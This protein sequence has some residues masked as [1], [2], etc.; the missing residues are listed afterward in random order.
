MCAREAAIV[1]WRAASAAT[2]I[3]SSC[4]A[5]PTP[6]VSTA[7]KASQR[8]GNEGSGITAFWVQG[9]GFR[10]YGLGLRANGVQATD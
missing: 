7:G 3:A 4:T 6:V 10:V 2:A 5:P 9:L 1:Q 8:P